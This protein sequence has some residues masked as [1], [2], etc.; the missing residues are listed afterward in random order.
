MITFD[1]AKL[2]FEFYR[3]K[4]VTTA[5]GGSITVV[6][7]DETIITGKEVHQRIGVPMALARNFIKRCSKVMKYLKPTWVCLAV[8]EEHVIAIERHPLSSM[9]VLSTKDEKGNESKW[10]PSMVSNWNLNLKPYVTTDHVDWFFDGRFVY[11]FE[12]PSVSHAVHQADAV[13]EDQ[14]F[15]QVETLCVDMQELQDVGQVAPH[16][17][18]C[19]AF[20]ADNGEYAVSPPIWKN[21]AAIGTSGR[22]KDDDDDDTV[23]GATVTHTMHNFDWI[24]VNMGVNLNFALKAGHDIGK[25]FGYEEVEPLHLARLMI[26][27][28]TVNL[29]NIHKSVKKTFDIGMQFSHAMAWLLGLSRRAN[30]LDSQIIMRSLMKYLTRTGVYRRDS[31]ENHKI[32]QEGATIADIPSADLTEL[33][34]RYSGQ[35]SLAS[36][37]EQTLANNIG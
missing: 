22:D 27:L 5:M 31:L 28:C 18:H 2:Q 11:K 23:S 30:T 6:N 32:F 36:I 26:E 25:T 19:L 12:S 8:Y 9:G 1:P 10:T 20:V 4:S 14:H 21:I 33:I 3:L 24:D 17:R 15:R 7:E 29:P 37:V 16:E 35:L 34:D 13:S